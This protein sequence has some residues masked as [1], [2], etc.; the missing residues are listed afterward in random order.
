[1][2]FTHK[3]GSYNEIKKLIKITPKNI[4][5]IIPW[6]YLQNKGGLIMPENLE[7][8]DENVVYVGKKPTM[9]YVL[10]VVT[11]FNNGAKNVVIKA[12]GKSIN[13]AVDIAEI[14]RNRF[15]NDL[16]YEVTLG[17][18]KIKSEDRESNVSSI[19]ILLKR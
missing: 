9:N 3:Y 14:V 16:K 10:A 11:Q 1:L 6:K 5:I 12:R 17:T 4:S 19:E 2:T 18:E 15:L 13:K 8:S 7:R